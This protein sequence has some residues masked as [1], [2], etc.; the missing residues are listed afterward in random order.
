MVDFPQVAQSVDTQS[1]IAQTIF[2]ALYCPQFPR[3][4][5]DCLPLLLGESKGRGF[6]FWTQYEF[7]SK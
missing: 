3:E 7:E 2:K 1:E 5:L 6:W 4:L